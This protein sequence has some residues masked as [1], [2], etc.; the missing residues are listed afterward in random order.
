MTDEILFERIGAWG[1]VTLNR[2]QALNALNRAM[3]IA[4][5]ARLSEWAADDGVRAV[6]VKGAG[7]R[8]FCAGGDIRALWEGG[9]N[10]AVKAAEF[11]HDEYE[12]NA[13]IFHYK[14]PYVA[15]IDGVT[16]GGGVGLSAGA[17]F[18]LAGDKTIWA[19][20]ET[21][22]GLFP[23]VGGGYFL[24]RL[25]GQTGM[26]LALTGQRL[27]AADCRYAGIATHGFSGDALSG[28]LTELLEEPLDGDAEAAIRRV[29]D[30]HADKRSGDILSAHREAIDRHFG[31]QT[32]A[33]VFSSLEA[34]GSN[35]A[36][37]TLV[38]LRRMSPMS[39]RLSFDHLR[40]GAE[41]EFDDVMKLEFRIASRLIA[42]RDFQEGVRAQIIDKDRNPKWAHASIADVR[43][44]EVAAFS[45]PFDDKGRELEI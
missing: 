32:L 23:D 26:F 3:C 45:A 27:K 10:D 38:T 20:P 39:L 14:K 35:W 24:P 4:M 29:L 42:S 31:A 5:K 16:M 7:D 28:A 6:L 36:R 11:F 18:R 37:D 41:M 43:D 25:E 44:A 17:T 8:A 12:L 1:V 2:P 19:M 21:A 30:V 15:V 40:A 13:Q 34:D 22:I 33:G 9:R